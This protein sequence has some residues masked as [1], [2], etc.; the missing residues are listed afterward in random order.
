MRHTRTQPHLSSFSPLPVFIS[1][2]PQAAAAIS[3]RQI[4]AALDDVTESGTLSPV[5]VTT[6]EAPETPI[7][8]AATSLADAEPE[9]VPVQEEEVQSTPASPA[10]RKRVSIAAQPVTEMP[11]TPKPRTRPTDGDE[12]RAQPRKSCL[13]ERPVAEEQAAAKV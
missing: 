8:T 1:S 13:K 12:A 3:D 4:E 6:D 7:E 11:P 10:P 5:P 2:D 9:I